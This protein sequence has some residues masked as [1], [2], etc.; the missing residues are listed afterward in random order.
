M[1]A[2]WAIEARRERASV[3]HARPLPEHV[4][5][6]VWLCDPTEPALVLGSSQPASHVDRVACDA[7]GVEVVRRRSGGGAVLLEPS[8]VLWVDV[9]IPS[10]DLLWHPD[11]GVAFHWLGITWAEALDDVGI[12]AAVHHGPLVR[13]RWSSHVCFAGLGPGEVTD[14]SGRKLVGM[15]QRRTRAGARFQCAVAAK[16]APD[17]LVPLLAV[18]PAERALMAAD[19]AD[20]AAGVGDLAALQQAFLARL[21]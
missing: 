12:R 21:P 18:E 2:G 7:A 10:D 5:R 13:T 16:W 4:T 15:A 3:T 9:L 20:A 1:T 17:A 11:V 14:P 19:L 8:A 6:T